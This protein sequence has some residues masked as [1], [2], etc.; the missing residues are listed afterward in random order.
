[1][2]KLVPILRTRQS[3]FMLSLHKEI[4]SIEIAVHQTSAEARADIHRLD[5]R[6]LRELSL[7]YEDTWLQLEDDMLASADRQNNLP[8]QSLPEVRKRM[9][10]S[11]TE[12]HRGCQELLT[13]AMMSAA[14]IGT[15]LW[16]VAGLKIMPKPLA[17]SAVRY[18][19]AGADDQGLKLTDR[20]TRLAHQTRQ[21]IGTTLQQQVMAANPAA[22]AIQTFRQQGKQPPTDL[23]AR[24]LLQQVDAVACSL[25]TALLTAQDSPHRRMAQLLR[26]GINRA[27]VEAYRV[28]MV[29]YPRAVGER[30]LL[31]P[32]NA[33]KSLGEIQT[34]LDLYGLGKGVYP[35]GKAPWTQHPMA[36]NF[37]EAVFADE[38]AK[39]P[40]LY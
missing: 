18:V 40:S 25:R 1:M 22:Q 7:L 37:I 26:S 19:Q 31:E 13:T 6:T 3:K 35:V 27:H 2:R 15:E 24:M 32:T 11:L 30:L 17:E 21:V 39:E 5:S 38:I 8:A 34:Q 9:D 33:R 29:A 28:A 4:S 12:L 36:L 20:L 23:L 10:T 14:E 16:Y